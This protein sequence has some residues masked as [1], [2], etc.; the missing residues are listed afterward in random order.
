MS[1][2][3]D[4]IIKLLPSREVVA[5]DFKKGMTSEDLS[6]ELSRIENDDI[7]PALIR[8]CMGAIRRAKIADSFTDYNDSGRP[9]L[10]WFKVTYDV[11][12]TK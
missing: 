2:R 3:Q 6:R 4:R 7:P 5:L 12:K 1:E 11:S 8:T 10:R 9:I